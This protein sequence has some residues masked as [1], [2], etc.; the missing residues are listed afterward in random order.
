MVFRDDKPLWT[1]NPSDIASSRLAEFMSFVST[2]HKIDMS[3]DRVGYDILH[4]FSIT[5]QSDFWL[6]VW[7]YF[8]VIGERGSDRVFVGGDRMDRGRYFPDSHLNYAEN[9]LVNLRMGDDTVIFRDEGGEERILKGVEFYNL[10]SRFAQALRSCGV[11]KGDRVAAIVP[12]IPASMIGFLATSSLGAI[13]SSCSPDFGVSGIEDRFSQID[14]KILLVCDGYHYNGRRHD[15]GKTVLS[16]ARFLSS[17]TNVIVIDHTGRGDGLVAQAQSCGFSHFI[18]W[19]DFIAPY[20]PGEI[21]FSRL[22]FDHPLYI[23]YSSGT[24]GRPKCIIHRSGGVLL[25]HFVEQGLHGGISSGDR[26]FFFTTCGW[27]M[28]NWLVSCLGC[29]GCVLLYDGSPLYPDSGCLFDFCAAHGANFMGVSAKYIDSVRKSDV[30]PQEIYDLSSLR[31]LFSTGSPLSAESFDFVYDKIG[32]DIHLSSISGGT[33]IVGCFVG[34]NPLLPVWRGEIQSKVLGMAVDIFSPDG[35]SLSSG[36]EESS[37]KGELVCTS[38]FP[39]MPLG[40]WNDPDGDA[41]YDA[42]FSYFPSI[43]RHGDFAEITT[44]G[45]IIVHGRSDATL[46]P[47][48]VRI[49][50]AEIYAQIESLPSIEES[51]AVGQEWD[52]DTRIILFVRLAPGISLDSDLEIEIRDSIRRKLSPRHVP[53]KVIAVGDI[54]RTRSGKIMELAVREVIHNRSVKNI[55][56]LANPESLAYFKDLDALKD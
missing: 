25:K 45:G 46:N 7:D 4:D 14:P 16:C 5:R 15:I 29:G 1:P 56:A 55:S 19:S 13:W 51:I 47:S 21:E 17:V 11:V 50:T 41:Y 12:N 52:G 49:G 8:G 3:I 38:P 10:V 37:G 36:K 32:Q 24:T 39:T 31:V 48:G 23:L 40:F 22:P 18:S 26:I 44:H 54:P 28:W 6:S 34:N 9:I 33:D 20:A 2:R 43:W 42:Y 27:M 30:H 53:A 35:V